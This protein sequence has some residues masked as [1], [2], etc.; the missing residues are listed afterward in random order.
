MRREVPKEDM[1]FARIIDKMPEEYNDGV[2]CKCDLIIYFKN[3]KP[4]EPVSIKCP[5][6]GFKIYYG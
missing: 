1:L 2:F 6:C 5:E 3:R 4:H